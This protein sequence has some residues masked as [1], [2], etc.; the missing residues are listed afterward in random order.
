[1]KKILSINNK[2][3]GLNSVKLFELIKKYD[4]S[5]AIYG[6]E[7]AAKDDTEQQYVI[8]FDENKSNDLNGMKRPKKEDFI[9]LF[10]KYQNLKFTYDI[11]HELVDGIKNTDLIQI[12]QERLTNIHIHTFDKTD[13]TDHH[14][15]LVDRFRH[16]LTIFELSLQLLFSR[17][18]GILVV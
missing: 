4:K 6:L 2:F 3:M 15:I 16:F 9:N 10:E 7:F 14:P 12:F 5:N 13:Y 18:F 11:G 17:F 8:Q 1:M